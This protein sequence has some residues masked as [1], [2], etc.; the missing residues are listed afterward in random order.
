MKPLKV[1]GTVKQITIGGKR[2]G[3]E[4]QDLKFVW[5]ELNL[6]KDSPILND[7]ACLY[8]PE[9]YFILPIEEARGIQIGQCVT[10]EIRD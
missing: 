2:A 6:P 10:I 3:S 5:I 4:A 1:E 8:T 9:L 7:R